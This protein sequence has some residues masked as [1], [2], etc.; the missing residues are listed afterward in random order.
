VVNTKQSLQIIIIYDP[1]PFSVRAGPGVAY[2]GFYTA[3]VREGVRG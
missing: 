2:E 1:F 3:S